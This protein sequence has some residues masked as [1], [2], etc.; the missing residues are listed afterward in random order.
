MLPVFHTS[1]T[2]ASLLLSAVLQADTVGSVLQPNPDCRFHHQPQ[3]LHPAATTDDWPHFLGPRHNNHCRE[4]QLRRDWPDAGPA[5]V[6]EMSRGASYA[7]PAIR[8]EHLVYPHRVGNDVAVDCLHPATG[9]R[10]W[11][12]SWPTEYRDHYGYQNGPRATPAISNDGLVYVYGA[13][14]HL[15]CLKLAS[16]EVRWQRDIAE[17]FGGR[18]QF[19]GTATSPLIEG[20]L[21]II[22]IG[23]PGGPCVAAFDRHSGELVWRAGN[24]WGPSYA[25]PVPADMHGRQ[26]LFVFAGG[27]SKPPVGGLLSL[28]ADDGQICDRFSWR[29]GT[30]ESVNASNPVVI[31]NRVLIS[32]SYGTGAAM[33]EVRPDGTLEKM[34]TSQ[35]GTHWSTAIT[36]GDHIYAIDGRHER[37]AALVCVE[38]A[39]GKVVWREIPEWADRIHD[40]AGGRDITMR[41]FRGT[42]LSADGDV[43]CLGEFGHLLWLDLQPSGYREISRTWLFP[44]P[45]TWTPPVISRG[46][47]YVCQNEPRLDNGG[48]RQLRCYDLRAP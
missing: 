43:L 6:W 9:A 47:L 10:Y 21:L 2:A 27:K 8:G 31:G 16:G 14:G 35:L 37:T 44:A 17:E 34:W 40:K 30:Y 4:T 19:F 25:T 23:A 26:R 3:P 7:A 46:L 28:T 12:H 33:L 22:N 45:Q 48:E 15:V 39:T 38:A 41:I 5:V 18:G 1:V 36:R 13:A 42:L 32:A 20:Q 29:S 24:Q 11:R